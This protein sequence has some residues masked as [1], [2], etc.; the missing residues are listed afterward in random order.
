MLSHALSLQE[1][2]DGQAQTLHQISC[3]FRA[4]QTFS[5]DAKREDGFV[6]FPAD[7]EGGLA[8]LELQVGFVFG[9]MS[10]RGLY[11]SGATPYR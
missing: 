10:V 3:L 4:L 2:P 6:C 11:A 9:G 8:L 5:P 7:A 1:L